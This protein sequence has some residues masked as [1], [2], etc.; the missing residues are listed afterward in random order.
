MPHEEEPMFY[1]NNVV[2]DSCYMAI[3]E[4][5]NLTNMAE[6]LEGAIARTA[7]KTSS[8]RDP[9]VEDG[10]L[11][12]RRYELV[13]LLEGT[14][15]DIC[16]KVSKIKTPT[17]VYDMLK[18]WLEQDRLNHS[19]VARVL[20]RSSAAPATSNQLNERRRRGRELHEAYIEAD[21]FRQE[22]AAK[23]ET[24]KRAMFQVR[25]ED[26]KAA[27][28]E[29]LIKRSE[30]LAKAETDLEAAKARYEDNQR[31]LEQGEAYFARSEFVQFCRSE[32]YRL[33]ALNLAN[34]L[35]G[36]PEIGWRQSMLR[37]QKEPC[38]GA[39][40]PAMQEFNAI[41]RIV[42]SGTRKSELVKHAE[43]W[44]RAHAKSKSYAISELRKNWYYLQKAI[45]T[46][47]E[48]RTWSRDLPS[49]ITKEYWRRK[50]SPTDV[51]RLFAEEEA[52]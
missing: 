40:G 46:A 26:D 2:Y 5:E 4:D 20:L 17:D 30:R 25:T 10:Q 32:R 34:A 45:Q 38:T 48:A 8:G 39:N 24:A 6:N 9:A 35:A 1:G 15:P 14:W 37:C 27:V 44:L 31:L 47:V 43:R 19:Y 22:C 42:R 51:H 36:L 23:L 28:Q 49:V 18:I 21:K 11:W 3:S 33:T 29:Q 7:A 12:T 16:G 13:F 52:L 50:N 41:E